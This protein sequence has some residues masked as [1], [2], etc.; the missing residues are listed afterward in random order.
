MPEQEITKE[1]IY[2][3]ISTALQIDGFSLEAKKARKRRTAGFLTFG[4]DT[5][6]TSRGYLPR[7]FKHPFLCQSDCN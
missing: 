3:R 7:L 1:Y 2:T 5:T 4:A 6:R